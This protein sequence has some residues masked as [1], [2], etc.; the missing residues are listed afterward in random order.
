MLNE[1]SAASSDSD[2]AATPI[3]PAKDE[4]PTPPLT[5]LGLAQD[6]DLIC[7]DEICAPVEPIR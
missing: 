6:D 4:P 5:L 1:S 2:A 3:E 7:V